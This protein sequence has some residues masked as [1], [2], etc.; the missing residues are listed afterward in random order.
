MIDLHSH[1][2]P[3]VDDGAKSFDEAL[4][5]LERFAQHGV[6]VLACTPH[7]DASRATEHPGE[8]HAKL[9]AEL[10]ARAPKEITIVAGYEIQLDLPG[11]DLTDPALH[12]GGSTAVLV[13]FAG[14]TVPP[15][16]TREL[17][18]LRAS[19]IIPVLA[20]PER[21]RGVTRDAVEEWRGTGAVMQVDSAMLFG[22][23]PMC[24]FARDLLERG[25]ADCLASDNHGDMRSLVAAR[26]WLEE[27]GATEQAT[28][29]TT[30]NPAR[31]LANEIVLPVDPIP[32]AEEGV[33]ARLRDLITGRS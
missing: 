1:L 3:G 7:L 28:L 18:R 6:T 15:N 23:A 32:E 16:A 9:R 8:E 20:H 14:M 17:Y 31:L 24:R 29:L 30:T 4:V 27:L 26:R 13:E 11:A 22:R 10:Q 12:L 25:L 19:G 33:L 2:L 5:V 21:Y